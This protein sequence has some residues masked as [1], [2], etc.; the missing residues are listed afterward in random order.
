MIIGWRIYYDNGQT[1]DA[2]RGPWSEAPEDGVVIVMLWETNSRGR[3]GK[4]ALYGFDHYFS[5]GDQVFGGNSD[6]RET[7]SD[8]YPG[9]RVIRGRW[10]SPATYDAVRQRALADTR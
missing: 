3:T 6:A 1:W 5:D 8:R 2:A 7:L 9:C 10:T 4:R